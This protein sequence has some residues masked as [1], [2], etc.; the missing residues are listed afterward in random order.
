MR[1]FCNHKQTIVRIL[2]QKKKT[3]EEL[4]ILK[5]AKLKTSTRNKKK[6]NGD[7]QKQSALPLIHSDQR[8][9]INCFKKARNSSGFP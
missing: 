2:K 7:I 9:N 6:I 8:D 4:E 3:F 5:T 1:A